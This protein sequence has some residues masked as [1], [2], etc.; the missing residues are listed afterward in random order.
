[1]RKKIYNSIHYPI[2]SKTGKE[3]G[4]G[5]FWETSGSTFF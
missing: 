5:G 1:M 2:L 3:S 4:E